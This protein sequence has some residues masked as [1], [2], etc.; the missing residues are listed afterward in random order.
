MSDGTDVSVQEVTTLPAP[1]EHCTEPSVIEVQDV[2]KVYRVYDHHGRG[3]LKAT[4]LPLARDRFSTTHVAL[5]RVSLSVERGEVVGVVGRNGSG[6]S[7]LL[8]LLAGMSHPTSGTV[9]VRGRLRCLMTSG[10]GFNPRLTGRQNML[11]GSVALGIPR[12]VADS[13]VD[14]MTAFAELQDHIDKPTMYYS[15]GMRG[16]LALAVALQEAPEVLILDEALSAGDA[17][18]SLKCRERIDEVCASGSTILVATHSLA[19]VQRACTRAVLLDNGKVRA[20][21]SPDEVSRA[22]EDVLSRAGA[23]P[24]AEE[25]S[26]ATAAR[27][28]RVCGASVLDGTGARVQHLQRG[29]PLTLRVGLE[30]L[31]PVDSPRIV[32]E[33]RTAAGV[34]VAQL[35]PHFVDART[36]GAAVLRPSRLSGEATLQLRWDS[37]PLGSGEY[38]WWLGIHPW[39]GGEALL[40]PA[41]ICRFRSRSFV[42]HDWRRDVILEQPSDL[43]LLEGTEHTRQSLIARLDTAAG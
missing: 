16:R 2:R 39:Q 19:F 11:F 14:A 41:E 27:A 24:I 4:L 15:T 34:R 3:W 25:P 28:I 6:K 42:E 7:T 20:E 29:E 21:G 9:R 23:A 32:L 33:L 36:G 10:I 17:G 30:A 38:A 5:D 8:K 18:F 22:Y 37:N 31:V 35:G 26:E 12:Q 43:E 1:S 13:R 40:A